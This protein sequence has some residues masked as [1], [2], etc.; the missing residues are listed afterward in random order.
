MS[1]SRPKTTKFMCRFCGSVFNI[2]DVSH[3]MDEWNKSG[4]LRDWIW[5]D[6]QCPKCKRGLDDWY[7]S[8]LSWPDHWR[9][10]VRYQRN[11]K[12]EVGE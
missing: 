7:I 1:K 8:N 10:A 5:V 3:P 4:I 12:T 2:E 6:D 9:D 11:I